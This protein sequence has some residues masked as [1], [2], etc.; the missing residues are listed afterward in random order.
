MG[1]DLDAGINSTIGVR[2]R[3]HHDA[4]VSALPEGSPIGDFAADLSRC[5]RRFC[6]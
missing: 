2:A 5:A 4:H 3:Y 1:I 6:R